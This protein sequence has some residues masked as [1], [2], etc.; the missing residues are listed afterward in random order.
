M[1]NPS[2]LKAGSGDGAAWQA[3][4]PSLAAERV[5]DSLLRAVSHDLRTPV[6]VAKLAVSSL[7][8]SDVVLD[9]VDRTELLAVADESLDRLIELVENLL[10]MTRLQSGKLPIMLEA[11]DLHVIAAQVLGALGRRG[12]TV[13]VQVP[14]SLPQVSA[15][16][17]LLEHAVVNV[18]RNAVQHS[19]ARRPP[20]LQAMPSAD[21]I[22][23]RIV[24]RGPGIPEAGWEQAFQPLQRYGDQHSR[25]GL[26][27]GLAVARGLIEAMGGTL[28]PEH[29]PGAGLTV[30]LSLPPFAEHTASPVRGS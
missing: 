29:T 20:L 27:L 13:D 5:R 10:E 1:S 8:S 9:A 11:V 25:E 26:G 2:P 22:E 19:S 16:P 3:V 7:R 24:D 6:T 14:E 17:S 30:V 12:R 15:D 21:R 4:A 18:V 23:L 28:F